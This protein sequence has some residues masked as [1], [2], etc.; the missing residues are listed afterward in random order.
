MP[1][2]ASQDHYSVLGVSES[3]STAE[4]QAPFRRLA[5]VH[6]PDKGGDPTRFRQI[7]EAQKV[8]SNERRRAL[9]DR[10]RKRNRATASKD[11]NAD[12][13]RE[14]TIRQL[15]EIT[16]AFAKINARVEEEKEVTRRRREGHRGP[17]DVSESQRNGRRAGSRGRRGPE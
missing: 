6:H 7:R 10:S 2:A 3:A 14:V 16:K 8:L 9:Y 13:Q 5:L 4:V 1:I 12:E 15:D 17:P 11:L